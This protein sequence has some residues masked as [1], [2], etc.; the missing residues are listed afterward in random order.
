MLSRSGEC[1]SPK[2]EIEG[3]EALVRVLVLSEGRSRP[4]EKSSPK[5]GFAASHWSTL[6]QARKFSLSETSPVAQAKASS[7]S[8]YSVVCVR[9]LYALMR[10]W[11]RRCCAMS[12][13]VCSVLTFERCCVRGRY[14]VGGSHVLDYG[15]V[16]KP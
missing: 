8:E 7:L 1:I 14:V 16:E 13:F 11:I 12:G 10:T 15:Q 4:G 9:C 5:R 3:C 6:A 2:R